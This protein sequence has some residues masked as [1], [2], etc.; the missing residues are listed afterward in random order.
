MYNEN[1][2]N[3]RY[4][5]WRRITLADW[6]A[7]EACKTIEIAHGYR[8]AFSNFKAPAKCINKFDCELHRR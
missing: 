2:K 4:W 3:R 6:T 1:I 5:R 8:I 7:L